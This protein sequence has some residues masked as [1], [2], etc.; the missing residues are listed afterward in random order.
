MERKE[1]LENLQKDLSSGR[2]MRCIFGHNDLLPPDYFICGNPDSLC[3]IPVIYPILL[4]ESRK[5]STNENIRI[6]VELPILGYVHQIERHTEDV[7]VRW[8]GPSTNI[9]SPAN[10]LKVV[11]FDSDNPDL[12]TYFVTLSNHL[13]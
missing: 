1:N 4:Q 10:E 5:H 6:C 3:G 7:T 13:K 12:L 11:V 2:W 9:T 8:P